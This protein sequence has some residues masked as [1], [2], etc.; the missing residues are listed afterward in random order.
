MSQSPAKVTQENDSTWI[1]GPVGHSDRVVLVARVVARGIH[2]PTEGNVSSW[3]PVGIRGRPTGHQW[4]APLVLDGRLVGLAVVVAAHL[5]GPGEAS[6]A[7]PTARI[8]GWD[9]PAGRPASED[10]LPVVG[11]HVGR[12][13]LAWDL[14]G[15][16][17]GGAI[18]LGGHRT[19][20]ELFKRSFHFQWNVFSQR[21]ERI[22]P[23]R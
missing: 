10:S 16:H 2:W 19:S 11:S 5:L 18:P 23:H 4:T 22:S 14:I 20:L 17:D 3:R 8:R 7:D 12:F 6:Q 15:H 1:D 9:V 21:I 13:Q